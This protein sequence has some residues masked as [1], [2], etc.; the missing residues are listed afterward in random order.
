MVAHAQPRLGAPAL[1]HVDGNV[2]GGL[3]LK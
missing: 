2:L 3:I 1:V